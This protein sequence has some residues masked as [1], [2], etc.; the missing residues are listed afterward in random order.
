MIKYIKMCYKEWLKMIKNIYHKL[1]K[2]NF[3][4]IIKKVFRDC[5]NKIIKY[6]IKNYKI[7]M[8]IIMKV[9]KYPL[10]KLLNFIK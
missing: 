6:N 2:K 4:K 3:S 7:M 9:M 1:W 5:Y 8:I 10:K